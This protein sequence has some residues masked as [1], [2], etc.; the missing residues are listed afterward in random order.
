MKYEW[1]K[2]T[3]MSLS[4][5]KYG[6]FFLNSPMDVHVEQSGEPPT[7]THHTG[8]NLTP[9]GEWIAAPG[10]DTVVAGHRDDDGG[11]DDDDDESVELSS[12]RFELGTALDKLAIAK[13]RIQE[14]ETEV[15]GIDSVI[16]NAMAPLHKIKEWALQPSNNTH[17][18]LAQAHVLKLVRGEA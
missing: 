5:G 1:N 15:A 10:L 6:V 17:L 16:A 7:Y 3:A 14:L 18:R 12:L 2:F 13:L 8:L 9:E 11:D 4:G